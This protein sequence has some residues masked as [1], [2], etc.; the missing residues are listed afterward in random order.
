MAKRRKST[1]RKRPP[2]GFQNPR[3]FTPAA[4][5]VL[6]GG[7][8]LIVIALLLAIG[9]LAPDTFSAFRSLTADDPGQTASSMSDVLRLEQLSWVVILSVMINGP[10]F[11]ASYW[12]LYSFPNHRRRYRWSTTYMP[13]LLAGMAVLTVILLGIASASGQEQAFNEQF[14]AFDQPDGA[15]S[16]LLSTFWAAC[17]Q[18]PCFVLARGIYM[19]MHAVSIFYLAWHYNGQGWGMTASFCYLAGLRLDAVE[20]RLIRSGYYA[21]TAVHVGWVLYYAAGEVGVL[22]APEISHWVMDGILTLTVLCYLVTLPLGVH[23]FR[24]AARRTGQPVPLRAV[25]PC[26]ASFSWYLLIYIHPYFF[27]VLQ[28]SHA[29]QYLAFPLRVEANRHSQVADAAPARRT[30]RLLLI[31][32]LLVGLGYLVFE[33]PVKLEMMDR[34]AI[35]PLEIAGLIAS[36]VNIHH[37]FADGA[38]WKISNPEVRGQLFSHLEPVAE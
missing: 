33:L 16:G 10:H 4:D 28:L 19:L 13:A 2:A 3:I 29:A 11:M 14:A 23:G 26:L 18:A 7:L 25:L 6:V 36:V 32:L 37:F 35:G 12:V 8:S 30:G 20:R 24:R 34:L 21:M 5:A 1:D 9:V 38:I 15:A 22:V 17:Q 27:L 31:Y